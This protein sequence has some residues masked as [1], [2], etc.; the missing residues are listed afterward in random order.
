MGGGSILLSALE[1]PER[2]L[3]KLHPTPSITNDDK[4]ETRKK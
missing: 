2:V 1:I 3:Y 4:L